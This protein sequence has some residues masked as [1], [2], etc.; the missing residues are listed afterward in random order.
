M[1]IQANKESYK[2]K[3]ILQ[4]SDKDKFVEA[5]NKEVTSLFKE[6]N[7][8]KIPWIKIPRQEEKIIMPNRGSKDI[9]LR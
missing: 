6:K 7:W 5:M 2:L 3:E 9:I 4:E 1:T 8:I